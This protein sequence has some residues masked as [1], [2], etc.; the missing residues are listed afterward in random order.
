MWL[1]ISRPPTLF[2]IWSKT[3]YHPPT[4]AP[5]RLG[6]VPA[7]ITT[8]TTNPSGR[9]GPSMMTCL[10]RLTLT[11]V[12]LA[13]PNLPHFPFV[14]CLMPPARMKVTVQRGVRVRM[15]LSDY[16][17][18]LLITL[19]LTSSAYEGSCTTQYGN[20][21]MT[22]TKTKKKKVNQPETSPNL[23]SCGRSCGMG[24]GGVRERLRHL[25]TGPGRRIG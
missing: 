5:S 22:L 24:S 18:P 8:T 21:P 20:P 1:V 23:P 12:S 25:S 11:T 15:R 19:T 3:P 16:Y 6:P 4:G 17:L 10:M 7:L 13:V 2:E 14:H 9:L